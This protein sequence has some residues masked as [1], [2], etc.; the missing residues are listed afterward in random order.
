MVL[1]IAS[2]TFVTVLSLCVLFIHLLSNNQNRI[3]ERLNQYVGGTEAIGIS[4]GTISETKQERGMGFRTVIRKV[5]KYFE[6]QYVSSLLENKLIQAGWP[7]RG[8]EF[9]VVCFGLIIFIFLIV[10]AV[11]SSIIFSFFIALFGS[12]F[13]FIVLKIAISKRAKAF[14]NQLGDTLGL[15]AN[16]LR[17]GYSF[18]QAIEMVSKEMP[19]PISVEFGRTLREMNLGVS[20]EEALNNLA[21]RVNSDDIDLVI[22][23]VLIQRQVGGNLS[24]ILDNIAGTIR[25]RIKIKGEIQTLTAQGKVSGLIIGIMPFVLGG[26]I[27]IINPEYISI[28][29]TQPMGKF[30]LIGALGSEMIGIFFIRKI[31]NIEV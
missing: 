8:S 2:I 23:A 28:L 5:S 6:S 1:L 22:T 31:V 25:E 20:T 30:M 15:I 3:K 18:L 16:S 10:L 27:Y 19:K 13:P 29:F 11:S 9:L 7:L 14:N 4:E 24:E 21:K 26:V 12:V 17:T